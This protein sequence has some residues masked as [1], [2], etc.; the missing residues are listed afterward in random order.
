[1]STS[2]DL[3]KDIFTKVASRSSME[4]TLREVATAYSSIKTAGAS[5]M[6][7]AGALGAIPAYMLGDMAARSEERD[8]RIKYLASGAAAGAALPILYNILSGSRDASDAM[9]IDADYIRD[10]QARAI[11]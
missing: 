2:G 1:M 7:L 4:E 3:Y 11:K 8:K 9:G 5:E 10:M 6:L